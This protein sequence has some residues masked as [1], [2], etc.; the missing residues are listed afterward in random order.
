[1]DTKRVGIQVGLTTNGEMHKYPEATEAEIDE[2]YL[3]VKQGDTK[4]ATYA[5]KEWSY[6]RYIQ[7]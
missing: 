6:V 3:Y 4:I 2:G 7:P 1:M 5:P